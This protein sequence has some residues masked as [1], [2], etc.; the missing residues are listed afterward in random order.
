MN[1]LIDNFFNEIKEYDFFKNDWKVYWSK[2]ENHLY[3]F[4]K[5]QKNL[6]NMK[7]ENFRKWK[8]EFRDLLFDE[9][10]K[11]NIEIPTNLKIRIF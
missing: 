10:S 1:Q 11:R 3:D 4:E 7:Y 2:I 9:F 6:K 8:K 5:Q